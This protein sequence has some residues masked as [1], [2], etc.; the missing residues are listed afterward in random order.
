MNE[1]EFLKLLKERLPELREALDKEKYFVVDKFMR[2]AQR[3]IYDEDR[4]CFEICV[5]LAEEA[6]LNGDKDM[7]SSI[8]T[9]FMENLEFVTPRRSHYWAW[10]MLPDS[11]K[12]LYVAFWGTW[13]VPDKPTHVWKP[14]KRR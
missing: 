3:A 14:P 2:H 13:K 1:S 11:L 12:E 6:Y 9:M 8:D 4:A 7:K 10:E 5:R